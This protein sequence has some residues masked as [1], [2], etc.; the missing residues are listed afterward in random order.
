MIQQ[1]ET[2]KDKKSENEVD[3]LKKYI[4]NIDKK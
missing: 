1:N 4:K 3:L 2:R